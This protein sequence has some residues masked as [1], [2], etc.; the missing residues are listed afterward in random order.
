MFGHESGRHSWAGLP[1]VYDRL[2]V[3]NRGHG[4]AIPD[5]WAPEGCRMVKMAVTKHEASAASTQFV[6]HPTRRLLAGL[7]VGG[8]PINT[9]GY[10]SL[11]GSWTRPSSTPLTYTMARRST[12]PRR[13]E[14]STGWKRRLRPSALGSTPAKQPRQPTRPTRT[15][16]RRRRT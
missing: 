14:G 7:G 3:T 9:Q 8:T 1:F 11:L 15:R 4:D 6:T 16:R 5:V 10:E 2:L 12:T 13:A